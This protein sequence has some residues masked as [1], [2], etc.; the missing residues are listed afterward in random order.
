MFALYADHALLG[1]GL[2]TFAPRYYR[3][4]DNQMLM[5]LLELG[6]IGLIVV[7]VF[8]ASALLMARS[9]MRQPVHPVSRHQAL[10]L[11]GA[12]L[13]VVSSYLTFDA[14]GFPMV[15]GMTFLLVGMIGGAYRVDRSSR[16]D[17]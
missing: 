8:L 5:I 10:A 6:A 14:W 12:L 16:M 17:A 11:A 13:G 2:F 15:A 9:V 4:L 3:I 7:L 1:R